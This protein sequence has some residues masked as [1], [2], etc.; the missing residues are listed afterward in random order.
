[1]VLLCGRH[2]KYVHARRII[3]VEDDTDR[4]TVR[5][6]DGTP[7]LVRPPPTLAA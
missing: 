1:L 3:L 7:L 4:W 6:P 2:H 5:R